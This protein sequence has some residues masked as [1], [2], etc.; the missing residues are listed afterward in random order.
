MNPRIGI[1]TCLMIDFFNGDE[2]AVKFVSSHEQDLVICEFSIFEFLC[3]RLTKKQEQVFLNG[4]DCLMHI[5][6]SRQATLVAS[7][8][9]REGKNS[10]KSMS[11][12]DALIAGSYLSEG[13]TRIA[14]Q[15]KQHFRGIQGLEI[16]DY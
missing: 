2:S 9:F 12:E 16:I 6:F 11:A 14:T 1:D 7:R 3:G 13:I 10:G 4:V 15:N 8:V 5:P